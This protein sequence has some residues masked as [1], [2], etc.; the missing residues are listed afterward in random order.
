MRSCA[1]FNAGL[2][3]VAILSTVTVLQAQSAGAKGLPSR[4]PTA[5][6]QI[7]ATGCLRRGNDGNY[8]LAGRDGQKWELSSTTV[9]LAQHL[10]HSVTVTGKPGARKSQAGK[11]PE[12]TGGSGLY[13]AR[14]LE[15]LSLKMLSP[16]CTR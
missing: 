6:G 5:S 1:T 2:M 3:L 10:M 16:S 15:V 14:P 11:K 13:G 7:Q 4:D 9:D 12:E 8:F